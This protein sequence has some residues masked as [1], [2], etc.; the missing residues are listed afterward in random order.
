M[1]KHIIILAAIIAAALLAPA[2]YP[3]DAPGLKTEGIT[4]SLFSDE[5]ETKAFDPT[6][7][8][9]IHH[10]DFYFFKDEA[11]NQPIANMHGRATG[12]S[13][14]LD[15][16][17]GQTYAA[18]RTGESFVYIIANYPGDH[19]TTTNMTLQEL[20]AL[21]VD[22]PILTGRETAR[23]PLTND[24][25]ETGV[26]T[27]NDNMVM[28]SY[29]KDTD[30]NEKYTVKISAPTSV[31]ERRTVE[32][33]LSRLA[34]KL[35]MVINVAD[36]VTGS[37]GGEVWTPVMSDLKAYYVN[38]LN[39]KTTVG[40]TPIERPVDTTGYG[41]ISYPIAYPV[42]ISDYT[43]TTDP[44]FTYPQR[45]ADSVN[46]DPY[47]KIQMT[48]SSNLR[49]ASPFFYKVRVPRATSGRKC[50]LNRNTFYTVTV[51]LTVVDTEHDF[52]EIDGSY[53]VTPW[54]DGL[55]P[56]GNSL[57]A[58]RFFKVPQTSFE[59][60]S[61][62]QIK[63]PYYSSSAVEAFFTDFDYYF[64]GEKDTKHYAF[65][66]D[67]SEETVTVTLPTRYNGTTIP[68]AGRDTNPYSL[69]VEG[70][71]VV[72]NHS[73]SNL[74]TRR[75]ITLVIRQKDNPTNSEVV[76]I[77]QHPAIE[78][79][80]HGTNSMFVN[81]YFGHVELPVDGNGQPFARQN[82]YTWQYAASN[83]GQTTFYHSTKNTNGTTLNQNGTFNFTDGEYGWGSVY[84]N[85]DFD[86]SISQTP[87]M[88]EVVVSAFNTENDTY[89]IR[90]GSASVDPA[91]KT[92]RIGDP[93][94]TARSQGYADRWVDKYLF[95]ETYTY[96][97][98]GTV[99]S[100]QEVTAAW[101]E[102][103]NIL[104]GS[105]D[106]LDREI[107]APRFLVSSA[108]NVT[109]GV[110]WYGAVRRAAT[111]QEAGYPAGR[112]RLPTEAEIA[113]IVARQKE[114]SIPTL[115]A[116]GSIYW[117]ADG[118]AVKALTGGTSPIVSYVVGSNPDGTNVSADRPLRFVYDL[119]YWGDEKMDSNQYH[120]NGH[121]VN[122]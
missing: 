29:H 85:T 40:A 2:C 72:F 66:Y 21:E 32:V 1:K 109:G 13:T 37:L 56:G 8:T 61:Q 71:N 44:A 12:A 97:S 87:F 9:A 7:E 62:N 90:Y 57:A 115:F 70:N 54:A 73:L 64:Y 59:L 14:D 27:F 82:S 104:I 89:E 19:P 98:N 120:A 119:W 36:Q 77:T 43:V 95:S 17:T 35:V 26:V 3:E 53:I 51:K 102:P 34:A 96:N 94:K 116:T 5:P 113:F 15:T 111:Y 52:V 47:F 50:V 103:Y 25:E 84:G 63:I 46:G 118:R 86:S 11:G 41:Y 28:D 45:W 49:G 6:F 38:A 81:G 88:T 75:N 68:A 55:K 107:I 122:H 92:Y 33:G 106:E 10:F 24:I 23:N 30:N 99:A 31:N 67:L 80:K 121:I 78:I 20:L 93:R 22:Y 83:P 60:Y 39:N 91:I 117:C 79:I 58:A 100:T 114:K 74:F 108:L 76:T 69:Q 4:L 16:R 105:Q 101:T 48:W 65:H 18:L 110:Q 42:T 112:W